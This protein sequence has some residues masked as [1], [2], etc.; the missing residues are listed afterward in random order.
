MAEGCKFVLEHNFASPTDGSPPTY[1]LGGP[2]V[3]GLEAT[4]LV[5]DDEPNGLTLSPDGTMLAIGT[6]QGVLLLA[7]PTLEKVGFAHTLAPIQ[8]VS[9]SP[10]GEALAASCEMRAGKRLSEWVRSV[11]QLN[12]PLS[13]PSIG[14]DAAPGQ[15]GYDCIV[16][17]AVETIIIGLQRSVGWSLEEAA[18]SS[19]ELHAL[20]NDVRSAAHKRDIRTHKLVEGVPSAIGILSSARTICK[21]SY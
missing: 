10:N 4:S 19:S 5:L 6:T 18:S 15:G 21:S 9:F 14:G 1:P 17:D 13:S 3:W 12:M 2:Q 7:V 11:T 16:I 20:V 8:T